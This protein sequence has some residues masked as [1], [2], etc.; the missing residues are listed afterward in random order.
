[1]DTNETTRPTDFTLLF[2]IG[3]LLSIYRDRLL[4]IPEHLRE[5][6]GLFS[7]LSWR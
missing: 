3:V 5:R 7:V 4:Q 6:K 1:M 2:A